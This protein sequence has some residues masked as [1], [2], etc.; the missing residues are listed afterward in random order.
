MIS[1]DPS[2]KLM[3][4]PVTVKQSGK[5]G[6]VRG[7]APASDKWWVIM[8]PVDLLDK[9]YYSEDELIIGEE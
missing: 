2:K 4:K 1:S 8:A 7:Y 5:K 9:G 3:G 6:T